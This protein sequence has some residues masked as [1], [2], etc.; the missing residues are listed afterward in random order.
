VHGFLADLIVV[1]HAAYVAFVVVGLV[2]V[3][4]GAWRGWSWVRN[5][6]FRIGHF[7]CILVVA[8][9]QLAG[10]ACPLTVWE[11]R[12]RVAAGQPVTGE[13]FVSRLLHGLIFFP[14]VPEWV[15]TVAY[16]TFAAVVAATLWWVP[17]R[18]SRADGGRAALAGSD[19][20]AVVQR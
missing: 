10:M 18:W 17:V 4:I 2:L 1:V 3:L 15:F 5:P 14:T 12:L 6:W 20:D 9:E 16:V 8:G 13:T 19:S 7:L 11:Y